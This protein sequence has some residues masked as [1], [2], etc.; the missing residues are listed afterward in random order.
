[1]LA[2][3]HVRARINK[4]ATR[5]VEQIAAQRNPVGIDAIKLIRQLPDAEPVFPR[6]D[7]DEREGGDDQCKADTDHRKASAPAPSQQ[8]DQQDSERP[9]WL[10]SEQ[11]P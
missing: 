8:R 10:E 5:Y 3:R 6:L 2:V 9:G 7:T 11:A 4:Q 1:A